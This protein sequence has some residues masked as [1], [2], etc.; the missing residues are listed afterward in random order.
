MRP[1]FFYPV[2][3]ETFDVALAQIDANDYAVQW[4][5]RGR[6]FVLFAMTIWKCQQR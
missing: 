4:E 2:D 6:N 5:A 1:R 3:D